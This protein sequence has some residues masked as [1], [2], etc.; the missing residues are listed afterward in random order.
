MKPLALILLILLVA[1]GLPIMAGMGGMEGMG[2]CPACLSGNS[3]NQ[4]GLCLGILALVLI[5]SGLV[6]IGRSLD[7]N[8]R[9]SGGLFALALFRP[10]RAV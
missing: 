8:F 2:W 10:P 7:S 1:A 5:L 3:A 4:T 9:M 6:L